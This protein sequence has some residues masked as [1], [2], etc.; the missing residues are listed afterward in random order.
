[1]LLSFQDDQTGFGNAY[2]PLAVIPAFTSQIASVFPQTSSDVT[3]TLEYFGDFDVGG[4]AEAL[5]INIEGVTFGPYTG[6]QYNGVLG[7]ATPTTVNL[8]ID[9][10]TW[11]SIIADRV[12]DISYD[13]GSASNNLSDAPNAEEFIK[14]TFSW[15][16]IPPKGT[17]GD[18]YILGTTDPDRIAG[19]AGNDRIFGGAGD[20]TL[21]GGNGDDIIRGGQG[22]DIIYGGQGNDK[23]YG[24]DGDD[25]LRS[26]GGNDKFWGGAGADTFIYSSQSGRDKIMDFE[27]GVDVIDL[28]KWKAVNSFEKVESHASE[29]GSD[30]WIKAGSE[31]L[32]IKNFGLSDLDAGDFRF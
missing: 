30:L 31:V 22:N 15:D 11:A 25:I 13:L 32:I 26:K 2:G 28:H 19:K 20:D 7:P 27:T 12:I 10:A 24:G 29:H 5:T 18:D 21:Y 14:L 23:L 17:A 3:I 4:T 9:Q 6:P 1:M 16:Y 8:T